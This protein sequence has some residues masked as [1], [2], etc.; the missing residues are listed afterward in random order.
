M[1]LKVLFANGKSCIC[2]CV[3]IPLSTLTKLRNSCLTKKGA[4]TKS[5]ANRSSMID[6]AFTFYC[7]IIYPCRNA[8][9]LPW[10]VFIATLLNRFFLLLFHKIGWLLQESNRPYTEIRWKSGHRDYLY[11]N[12]TVSRIQVLGR[13]STRTVKNSLHLDPGNRSR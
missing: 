13:I 1:F 11:R 2:D 4:C 12:K 3:F 7:A 5:W 9:F 10:T 8:F 6:G